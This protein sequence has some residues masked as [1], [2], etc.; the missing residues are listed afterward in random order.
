MKT[1]DLIVGARP[2]FMKIASLYEA[3]QNQTSFK[4]KYNLRLIHTGQHYDEAMSDTFFSDLNIPIPE[5]N[6]GV[7]S[8]SHAEQTSKIMMAYESLLDNSE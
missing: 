4:E 8:G 2:N 6:F 7:G 1:I 5:I 3:I